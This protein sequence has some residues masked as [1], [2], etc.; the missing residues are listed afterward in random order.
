MVLDLIFPKEAA[1]A[2]HNYSSSKP[3]VQTTNEKGELTQ[4]SQACLSH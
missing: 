4:Q 3:S 1:L 2:L